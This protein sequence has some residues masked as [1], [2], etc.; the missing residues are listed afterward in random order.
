MGWSVRG[1]LVAR[2]SKDEQS[3]HDLAT[4]KQ[5]MEMDQGW[6]E[7]VPTPTG[8]HRPCTA[9]L[10]PPPLELRCRRHQG[11]RGTPNVTYLGLKW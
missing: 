10:Q 7:V 9:P 6:E 1:F 2:T 3:I 5:K 11:G 8:Q 4:E